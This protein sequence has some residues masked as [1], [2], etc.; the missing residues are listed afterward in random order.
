MDAVKGDCTLRVL[1]ILFQSGAATLTAEGTKTVDQA[2]TAI[3][4]NFPQYRVLVKGH[5]TPSG[6]EAANL[7]LSQERAEAVK[8]YLETVRGIDSNR[9]R[10]AGVGSREPLLRPPGEG[11]L[12][13]PFRLARVE[14][15]L[16]E[17]KR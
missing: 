4:H 7:R 5:T 2:A 1:P 3:V 15:I 8:N 13:Y 9:L 17:D 6:D 11:D 10:A 16:L 14:F 12:S